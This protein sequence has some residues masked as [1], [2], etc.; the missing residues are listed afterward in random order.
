MIGPCHHAP[1]ALLQ[2]PPQ[3]FTRVLVDVPCSG[4]GVLAKRADLRWRRE[5][6]DL[7]E[8]VTLQVICLA[9]RFS[10]ACSTST[11]QVQVRTFLGV[12]AKRADLRRR[13]E[14]AD[15]EELVTLQVY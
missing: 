2:A 1:D 13:R 3:Q 12:L 10:E 5:P 4:L 11:S 14:P 15:L 9:R 7:D 8:L 6:A